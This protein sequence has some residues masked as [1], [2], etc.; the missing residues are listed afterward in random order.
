L[1]ENVYDS[2][3]KKERNKE[4]KKKKE[5]WEKGSVTDYILI[6]LGLPGSI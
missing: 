4:R 1:I 2:E 6:I 5:I 3:G